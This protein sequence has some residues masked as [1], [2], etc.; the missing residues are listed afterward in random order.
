VA[1]LAR[2]RNI[3]MSKGIRYVYI[4]NVPNHPGNHTYCPKCGKAVV[5]R[6]SF[7]ITE[8]N[9]ESGKCKFCGRAIAGVW[10]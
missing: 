6:S 8:M 5:R 10:T 4:G 2:S 1:T 7:F 9:V 3:A